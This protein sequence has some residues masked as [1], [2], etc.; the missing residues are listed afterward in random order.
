MVLDPTIPSWPLVPEGRKEAMWQLLSRTFIVPRGTREQVKHY[1]LKM[2]GETFRRWKSEL[3]K[4]YVQKGRTPFANYGDITPAQWEEFVR[5]K[6]TEEALAR[7]QKQTKL[8]KSN[9]HKVRLGPGR[10]QRKIDGWQCEREAAIAASQP[11]PYEGLDDRG[12]QWLE[13]RKPKIVERQ[14]KI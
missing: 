1:A 8:A 9:I 6:T 12:W 7:S 14:T 5:Q 10:Y 3:N 13:A 11:D 2:L 4:R